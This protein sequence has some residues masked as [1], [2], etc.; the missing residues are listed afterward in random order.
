MNMKNVQIICI[1]LSW[2]QFS[3]ASEEEWS[4]KRVRI[5]RPGIK[6]N[7]W[8]YTDLNQHRIQQIVGRYALFVLSALKPRCYYVK[9]SIARLDFS[10]GSEQAK[11][12]VGLFPEGSIIVKLPDSPE[13]FLSYRC[14]NGTVWSVPL[15][16]LPAMRKYPSS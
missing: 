4:L 12:Y 10:R 3:C 2:F 8:N 5:R 6:L 7:R 15:S 16:H 11:R 9:S 14:L 1:F 13:D